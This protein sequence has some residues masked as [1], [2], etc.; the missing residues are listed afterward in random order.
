MLISILSSRGLRG[1]NQYYVD[2]ELSLPY[3]KHLLN[4]LNIFPN[5]LPFTT[6]RKNL[7]SHGFIVEF[8]LF[9]QYLNEK[10]SVFT[11]LLF[12]SLIIR[13]LLIIDR[14]TIIQAAFF[15]LPVVMASNGLCTKDTWL[16]VGF[17]EA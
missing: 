1:L 16:R 8:F 13:R 17:Q 9:T 5:L 7:Y 4:S 6:T 3:L 14:R 10:G 15:N 11:L 12:S 2:R